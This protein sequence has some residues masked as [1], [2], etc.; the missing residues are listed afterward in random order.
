MNEFLSLSLEDKKRLI[1]NISRELNMSEAIIEKDFWVCWILHYL[2]TDFKYKDFICF[3]GGTSLSKA[4]HCIERFS[5]DVDLA[6]DW[7][8]LG[9]L[10]EEAYASRSNR[11]QEFFIKKPIV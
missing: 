6:L 1:I 4:Y 11:Q 9:F 8:V 10:K 7:S 2:F 5:E 3:K